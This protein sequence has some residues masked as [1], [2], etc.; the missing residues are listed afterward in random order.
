MI[1]EKQRKMVNVILMGI[2]S[3]TKESTVLYS[4][5]LVKFDLIP[6]KRELLKLSL[7]VP[8]GKTSGQG[9]SGLMNHETGKNLTF[10]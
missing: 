10:I 3:N 2:F 7:E 4:G 5:L 6:N 9:S 1:K 8:A